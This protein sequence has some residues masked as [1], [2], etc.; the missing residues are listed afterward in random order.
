MSNV[1]IYWLSCNAADPNGEFIYHRRIFATISNIFLY[2]V[3]RVM[4]KI[5]I[6]RFLFLPYIN[7]FKL[8]RPEMHLA[9]HH[10]FPKYF[11]S[12]SPFLLSW[13]RI[14]FELEST[15]A[16]LYL[17]TSMLGTRVAFR[18]TNMRGTTCAIQHWFARLTRACTPTC[19]CDYIKGTVPNSSK[20]IQNLH[21][22]TN[23]KVEIN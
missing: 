1:K 11:L 20:H 17:R 22:R 14:R 5:A 7:D 18:Y 4:Y 23:K 8:C 16:A 15:S 21:I 13:I 2:A 3:L 12:W 19:S 9:V 6:A 10:E